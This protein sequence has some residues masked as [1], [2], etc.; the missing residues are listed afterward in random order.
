MIASRWNANSRKP[1][2]LSSGHHPAY[3]Q[4]VSGGLHLCQRTQP[5]GLN[6][7]TRWWTGWNST[8]KNRNEA[9]FWN[10]LA[11]YLSEM[12]PAPPGIS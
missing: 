8:R 1:G 12:E 4:A 5:L 7:T 9:E 11:L 10:Y 2:A 3:R 6:V